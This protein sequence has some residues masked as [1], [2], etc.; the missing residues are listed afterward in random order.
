MPSS[1]LPVLDNSDLIRYILDC[2]RLVKICTQVEY[3]DGWVRNDGS[4]PAFRNYR[5]HHRRSKKIHDQNQ[6]KNNLVPSTFGRIQKS[7]SAILKA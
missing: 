6:A 3:V 5:S 2:K 1:L 4:R 7:L